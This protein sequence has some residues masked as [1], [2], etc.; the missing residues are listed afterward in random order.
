MANSILKYQN[1]DFQDLTIDP[2]I[3]KQHIYYLL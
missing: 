2:I 1:I 3:I